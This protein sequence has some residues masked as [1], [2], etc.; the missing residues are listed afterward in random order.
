MKATTEE[1]AVKEV[2][3]KVATTE[4]RRF[5]ECV[6]PGLF[7][8]VWD[9]WDVEEMGPE[10]RYDRI[11]VEVEVGD[12]RRRYTA[13]EATTEKATTEKAIAKKAAA[14]GETAGQGRG[15]SMG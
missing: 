7:E 15:F 9:V 14:E 6:S 4:V 12:N 3:D 1:E 8:V 10:A 13:K 11:T 2:A 5:G